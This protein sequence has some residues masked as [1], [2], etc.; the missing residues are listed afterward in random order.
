MDH[1]SPAT[2]ADQANLVWDGAQLLSGLTAAARWLEQH[3]DAVNALNVFPV[4]DGDTGTNMALTLNGAVQDVAPDLSV[5]V[6]SE[7]VKYWAMMR[8][9]G[10]SGII[11]SQVLRGL[12][13][14][15]DGHDLMVWEESVFLDRE[16]PVSR[17]NVTQNENAL[18][19]GGAAEFLRSA[20]Q[21]YRCI[22]DAT[23]C[24]IGH[25]NREL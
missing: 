3:A 9:R 7:K 16:C 11:L 2:I 4:P 18:I 20:A 23:T 12:A 22:R 6:V 8:G 15:L 10:N 1:Q 13:Q 19:I 17:R 25:S 5:A 21:N 14:G 24:S